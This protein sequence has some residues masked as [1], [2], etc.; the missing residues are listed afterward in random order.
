MIDFED[1][2]RKIEVIDKHIS[3]DHNN[4]NYTNYYFK[5]LSTKKD[6]LKIE[7]INFSWCIFES[8]HILK[9]RFIN[10]NFTGCKFINSNFTGSSFDDCIFNYAIF[11]KTFIDHIILETKF[12]TYEQSENLQLKFVRSLR[13]DDPVFSLANK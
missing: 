2:Y 10:C 6:R 1:G 13:L 5:R 11:E 9:C 7:G 12:Q 3:S 8:C 4:Q